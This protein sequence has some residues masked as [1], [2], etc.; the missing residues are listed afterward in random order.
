ML[1]CGFPDS[2]WSARISNSR[3][4]IL[5]ADFEHTPMHSDLAGPDAVCHRHPAQVGRQDFRAIGHRE[6]AAA[7]APDGGG[8]DQK[9]FLIWLSPWQ[10]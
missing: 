3:Q 6:Y 9:S 4:G 5:E 10:R 1:E 2:D 7:A 8:G